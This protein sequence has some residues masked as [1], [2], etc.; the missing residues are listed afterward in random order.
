MTLKVKRRVVPVGV[1]IL[2]NLK[3]PLSILKPGMKVPLIT[4]RDLGKKDLGILRK[5]R[6]AP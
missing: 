2:L 3:M 5:K 4:L 6:K 1:K